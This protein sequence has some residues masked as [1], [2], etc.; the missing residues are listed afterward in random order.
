MQ[1]LDSFIPEIIWKYDDGQTVIFPGMK[2]ASSGLLFAGGFSSASGH[3]HLVQGHGNHE[4]LPQG[5]FRAHR[6]R[7]IALGALQQALDYHT[8]GDPDR[9]AL[10]ATWGAGQARHV[11]GH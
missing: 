10:A 1:G 8:Q 11:R 2:S 9:R 3:R 7:G 6:W 5:H 4:L